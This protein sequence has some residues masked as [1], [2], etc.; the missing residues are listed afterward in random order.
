MKQRN[1]PVSF[2]D[3]SGEGWQGIA[4]D[5]LREIQSLTGLTFE[6]TGDGS[7]N[8]PPPMAS[9]PS[10][11]GAPA[12]RSLRADQP[13]THDRYALISRI[14]RE[15]VRIDEVPDYRVGAI[16]DDSGEAFF[17]SCFPDAEP[18]LVSSR[19][20]AFDKLDAGALDLFMERPT[21]K[22][23]YLFDDACDPVFAFREDERALRGIVSKA[24]RFVDTGSISNE[25]RFR[26]FDYRRK[27]ARELRLSLLAAIALMSAVLAALLALFRKNRRI[28]AD[29]ERMVEE[30]TDE[31][32]RLTVAANAARYAKG[33]FLSRIS[34][35]MCHTLDAIAIMAR[36]IGGTE[37]ATKRKDLAGRIDR[38]SKHL[39]SIIDDILEMSSN[40]SGTQKTRKTAFNLEEMLG[41]ISAVVDCWAAEKSRHFLLTLPPDVPRRIVGDEPHIAQVLANFLSSIFTFSPTGSVVRL[42][43]SHTGGPVDAPGE[44]RLRFAV[45]NRDASLSQEEMDGQ[46][47]ETTGTGLPLAIQWIEAMGGTFEANAHPGDGTTLSFTISVLPVEEESPPEQPHDIPPTGAYRVL[48]VD[49]VEINREIAAA[50]LEDALIAVDFAENGRA[51]LECFG[52]E[53]DAYDLILMDIQMPEMNG[54]DATLAIRAMDHPHAKTVPILAMTANVFEEDIKTYRAAGMNDY[55]GKPLD[56]ADL[57]QKLAQYLAGS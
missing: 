35:E 6:P 40:D 2:L 11:S 30:R 34:R 18:I 57:L 12:E 23:N 32:K 44:I 56:P 15:N 45:H 49:D 25:W 27:A 51:A 21:F 54:L 5:V 17:R 31:L 24:Q 47:A 28:R 55:I 38:A 36:E 9:D 53:P 13:Y 48:V 33:T 52:K 3:E 29:L 41:N 16:R 22:L 42:D 20:E 4:V 7:P 8:A 37:A 43:I 19:A 46:L 50:Y 39:Q 14:D 10:L 1:Y 26:T